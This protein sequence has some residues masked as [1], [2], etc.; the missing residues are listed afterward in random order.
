MINKNNKPHISR[1]NNQQHAGFSII[2]LLVASGIGM[3]IVMGVMTL[4]ASNK[5]T[6][7]LQESMS[8][9]QRN[10]NFALDRL[11]RSIQEAGY[12]GFYPSYID[13]VENALTSPTDAKWNIVQPITGYESVTATDDYLGITGLIA[14]SDAI[15]LK[16]MKSTTNLISASTSSTAILDTASGYATG[17]IIIM[18]DQDQASM[19]QAINADNASTPGQTTVTI[20]ATTTP[21]PG[22]AAVLGNTF[23]VNA[24]VGKL[25]SVLYYLKNGTGSRPALFEARLITSADN[26]PTMSEKE[27]ISNVEDMQ[28]VYGVDTDLDG[29]IDNYSTAST[30]TTNTQW[31]NVRN[32]GVSLLLASERDNISQAPNSYSFNAT[33]FN[34]IEDAVTADGADRRMRRAFTTYITMKN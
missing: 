7:R 21:A 18:T 9:V 26:A 6:Y 32:V 22:N 11:R 15:A 5:D 14:G 24:T 19:F 31:G 13:G 28:I 25:D 12:S 16:T 3:F 17:D 20:T 8:Y 34:F 2:E 4:Y 10:G 33:K 1:P 29:D 27:L 23:G 30:V